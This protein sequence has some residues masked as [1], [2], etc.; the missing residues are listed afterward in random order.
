MNTHELNAFC[1]IC[2][3]LIA[4]GEGSIWLRSAD[5]VHA[6]RVTTAREEGR[7][8]KQRDGSAASPGAQPS[9]LRETAEWNVTHSVCDPGADAAIYR[10][11]VHQCRTWAGLVNWTAHLMEKSW[12]RHTDWI[13][14]LRSASEGE[15][16]RITPTTK[17]RL[18]V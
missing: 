5:L 18:G 13:E 6:E 3:G 10:F 17:A 1:D 4:D 12:L 15:G 2:N 16:G 14:L 11:E 8:T 9:G 7:H